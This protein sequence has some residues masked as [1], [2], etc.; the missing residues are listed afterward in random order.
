MLP[1]HTDDLFTNYSVHILN[2]FFFLGGV[3]DFLYG[4]PVGSRVNS[5]LLYIQVLPGKEKGSLK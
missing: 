2:T 4:H 3:F 1:Q 5:D